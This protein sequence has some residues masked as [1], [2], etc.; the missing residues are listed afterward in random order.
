M[1]TTGQAIDLPEHHDFISVQQAAKLL[2]L[3]ITRIRYF[4]SAGRLKG[5]FIGSNIA[6]SRKDVA[7]FGQTPRVAGRRK[8]YVPAQR[9]AK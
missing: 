7:A 1:K 5:W 4:L 2:G 3:S 8:G 9:V 6:L